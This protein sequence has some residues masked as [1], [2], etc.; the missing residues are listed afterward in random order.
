MKKNLIEND[1][2]KM[3]LLIDH[4]IGQPINEQVEK[5]ELE[6]L[7]NTANL[8]KKGYTIDDSELSKMG[9]REVILAYFPMADPKWR[10]KKKDLET[11]IKNSVPKQKEIIQ[12]V[13]SQLKKAENKKIID[14][15]FSKKVGSIDLGWF[16]DWSLGYFNLDYYVKLLEAKLQNYSNNSFTGKLQVVGRASVPDGIFEDAALTVVTTTD[17]TLGFNG[18]FSSDGNNV[19]LNIYP[20]K[21]NITSSWVS[22]KKI[23]SGLSSSVKAAIAVL[24]PLSYLVRFRFYNNDLQLELRAFD[25]TW[26]DTTIATLNAVGWLKVYCKNVKVTIPVKEFRSQGLPNSVQ[27]FESLAKK[28]AGGVADIKVDVEPDKEKQQQVKKLGF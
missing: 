20:K 12:Q 18:K 22:I 24:F 1:I 27:G 14:D 4:T 25:K 21:V 28:V 23:F 13:N 9:R 2:K 19:I 15:K 10:P 6:W 5:V 26:F 16:G 3:K 7:K 17:F 11:Y 8:I